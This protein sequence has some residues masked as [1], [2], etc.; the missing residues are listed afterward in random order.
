MWEIAASRASRAKQLGRRER[1]YPV[2]YSDHS[3][4]HSSDLLASTF[5]HEGLWKQANQAD[6]C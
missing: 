1:K 4:E 3:V 5:T 2:S 6:G